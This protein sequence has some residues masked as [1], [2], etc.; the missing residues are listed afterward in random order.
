MEATLLTYLDHQTIY[1]TKSK[2]IDIIINEKG[3]T[4]IILD[5][6]ILYPQGGGQPYDQGY[7][8]CD[9]NIFK[10]NEVRFSEGIVYH[11]GTYESGMLKIG[12]EVKCRIDIERRLRNARAHGAGHLIAFILKRLPYKLTPQN[13]HHF[14]GECY[15]GCEGEI[16]ENE[17]E[18]AREKIETLCNQIIG[19]EI[20]VTVAFIDR[21]EMERVCTL[22]PKEI[23]KDKPCRVM[24]VT[25]PNAGKS[26]VPC[27]GTHVANLRE[28]GKLVIS[29]VKVKKGMTKIS[30]E[31]E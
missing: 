24:S 17:R 20:P 12:D 15:I 9:E 16:P 6:T 3:E 22:I 8:T 28:I 31:C 21:S 11:V 2:I 23:P 19:L 10:V 29:K 30:Y 26:A 25:L 13:G 1:E 4:C 18:V 14:P 27:G 7:L 5:H